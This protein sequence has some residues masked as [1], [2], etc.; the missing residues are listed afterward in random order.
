MNKTI[1]QTAWDSLEK[2][3]PYPKKARKVKTVD[4]KKFKQEVLNESP[5]FVKEITSSLFGGDIYILK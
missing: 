1:Y 3:F 4:Y 5:A 2:R